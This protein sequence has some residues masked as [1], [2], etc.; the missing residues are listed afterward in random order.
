MTLSI[1][2]V[3]VYGL[4]ATLRI[5]ISHYAICRIIFIV[6]LNV[7]MLRVIMLSVAKLSVVMLNVIR[8]GVMAT[9]CFGLNKASLVE[10]EGS[11]SGLYMYGLNRCNNPSYFRLYS[12]PR[13][14]YI[15]LSI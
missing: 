10:G 13:F 3:S 4:F 15:Y 8:L 7:V 9:R 6:M 2:T 11:L 14:L 12:S 5:I 1:T